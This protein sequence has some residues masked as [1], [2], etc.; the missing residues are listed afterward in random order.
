MGIEGISPNQLRIEP[1][2]VQNVQNAAQFEKKVDGLSQ[3]KKINSDEEKEKNLQQNNADDK[4][5]NENN[6]QEEEI[7]VINYDLSDTK[8]Y[9]LKI[10]ENSN[11]VL[12]I[13]KDTQEV[14]QVFSAKVLSNLTGFLN[15]GNG[16]LVNRKF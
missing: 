8:K 2:N 11:N 4:D 16:V 14:I 15:E 12:I 13:K 5:Q 10:D 9:Q 7:E 6:A 3:G 1:Q